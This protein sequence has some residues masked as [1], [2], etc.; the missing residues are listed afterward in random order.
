MTK[1][2]WRGILLNTFHLLS[3]FLVKVDIT[4]QDGDV[5]GYSKLSNWKPRQ[6]SVESDRTFFGVTK[7]GRTCRDAT[8]WDCYHYDLEWKTWNVVTRPW[9]MAM[10]REIGATVL[11]YKRKRIETGCTDVPTGWP[12]NNEYTMQD[13]CGWDSWEGKSICSWKCGSELL[14]VIQFERPWGILMHNSGGTNLSWASNM[15]C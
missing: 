6:Y 4:G 5:I 3:D 9:S 15:P 13:I 1:A 8:V 12:P 7:P 10:W 14:R 11:T 2:G